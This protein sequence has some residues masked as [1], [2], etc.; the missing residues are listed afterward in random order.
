MKK[1]LVLMKKNAAVSFNKV[2]PISKMQVTNSVESFALKNAI[3]CATVDRQIAVEFDDKVKA[4]STTDSSLVHLASIPSSDADEVF[5]GST[6]VLTT[7]GALVKQI[8]SVASRC[9][10]ERTIGTPGLGSI[11]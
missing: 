5:N 10:V 11:E 6:Q 1:L 7:N 2:I 8:L 9:S 4:N 3:E